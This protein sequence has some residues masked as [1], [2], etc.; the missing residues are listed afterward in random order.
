MSGSK[1]QAVE[2]EIS[3]EELE[4]LKEKHGVKFCPSRQRAL[5]KIT[6]KVLADNLDGTL[7]ST[8]SGSKD[9]QITRSGGI[10]RRNR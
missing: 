9:Q 10:G 6:D 8:F 4:K 3:D 7:K 1:S 5:Q 2:I